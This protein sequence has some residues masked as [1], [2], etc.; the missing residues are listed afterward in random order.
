MP[1]CSRLSP[2]ADS[3]SRRERATLAA[4]ICSVSRIENATTHGRASHRQS[5]PMKKPSV[6]LDTNIISAYWY[7]GS[8]VAA[9]ARRASTRAW[10]EQERENFSVWGSAASED[11]LAAG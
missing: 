8:D 11:E 9:L 10:W 5:V 1:Q 7:S 4:E 6:Y 3:R 2:R